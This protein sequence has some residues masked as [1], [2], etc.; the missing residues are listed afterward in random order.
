MRVGAYVALLL[1]LILV[2]VIVVVV[3]IVVNI[4]AG[5]ESSR[6]DPILSYS[7]SQVA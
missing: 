4:V 5:V 3:V 7:F 2:L 6:V 1:V